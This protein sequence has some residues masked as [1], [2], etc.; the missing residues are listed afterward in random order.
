MKKLVLMI[1][2]ILFTTPV[3]GL[4][5]DTSVDEE[6]RKNYN[7]SKPEALPMLPAVNATVDYRE[8]SSVTAGKI[9]AGTKL[10][11]TLRNALTSG[12]PA[13]RSVTFYSASPVTKRGV[14][15][16]AQTV[17]QG[18]VTDSHPPQL[19]GNG[20]LLVLK[21]DR[22]QLNGRT[23]PVNAY[24]TKANGKKVFLNNIKGKR[25]YLRGVAKS[26]QPGRTYYHNTVNASQ[27]LAGIPLIM[28]ISPL[29]VLTGVVFLG[30]NTAGSPLF[31]LFYKGAE[32]VIPAGAQFDVKLIDELRL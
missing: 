21:I 15:I 28:L 32:L 7:P 29:P 27:E 11:L 10:R 20:G 31:G 5:L 18:V 22:M 19:A 26:T 6:I 23:C 16:P 14:T 25:G 3:F 4:E 8:N 9:P 13:G 17:F 1:F 2:F 12:A 24:V 30:L